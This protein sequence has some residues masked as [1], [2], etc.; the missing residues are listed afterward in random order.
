MNDFEAFLTRLADHE[1]EVCKSKLD[2]RSRILVN[3]GIRLNWTGD[4]LANP[5][6]EFQLI[7][8]PV[9]NILFAGTEPGWNKILIDQ[10]HAS[11]QEF[12]TLFESNEDI[13]NKFLQEASFSEEP[14]LLIPAGNQGFYSVFD[15]MHRFVGAILK[16]KNTVTGYAPVNAGRQLPVC[17]AHVVYDLIRGFQRNARNEEGRHDLFCALRLLCRI[18]ANV[19]ALLEN[20]FNMEYVADVEVQQVIRDV[21]EKV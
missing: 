17:E 18:Y 16:D 13:R 6:M 2:A 5:A 15:G 11:V 9:N 7:E 14:L 20:R 4:Y 19:P 12:R 3:A 8:V 10:C 21:L 1:D